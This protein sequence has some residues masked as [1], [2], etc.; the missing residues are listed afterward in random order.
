MSCT[1][2]IAARRNI[3]RLE[4]ASKV[5]ISLENICGVSLYIELQFRGPLKEQLP[6]SWTTCL[7][8]TARCAVSC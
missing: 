5:G 1:A 6:R 2:D 7:V 4:L 8:Q 3:E